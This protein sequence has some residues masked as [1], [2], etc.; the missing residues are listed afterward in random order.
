M[1]APRVLQPRLPLVLQ[2]V[3]LIQ[4][5]FLL[6]GPGRCC[7]D[8]CVF[9]TLMILLPSKVCTIGRPDLCLSRRL[10]PGPSCKIILSESCSPAFL[11]QLVFVLLSW[12]HGTW[13]HVNLH[14]T[15]S[16]PRGVGALVWHG[17]CHRHFYIPHNLSN[18][19]CKYSPS[20]PPR[21][22]SMWPV[23]LAA[24]LWDGKASPSEA[25]HRGALWQSPSNAAP[26]STRSGDHGISELL[27]TLGDIKPNSFWRWVCGFPERLCNSIEVT[28]P[29]VF[30]AGPEKSHLTHSSVTAPPFVT[31]LLI[32]AFPWLLGQG[33]LLI[34][35]LEK[36]AKAVRRG[37]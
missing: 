17:M 29:L 3:P 18:S 34:L 36:I 7:L 30:R 8:F 5:D 24:N 12:Y 2:K 11:P 26:P 32:I 22:F 23:T 21:P 15:V 19:S 9:S 13:T 35:I 33:R 25:S 31:L 37:K 4:D 20:F 16:S 10:F 6:T 1:E 27:R 28:Q 14:I